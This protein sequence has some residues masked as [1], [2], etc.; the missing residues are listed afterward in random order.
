[1]RI[2]SWSPLPAMF[3]LGLSAG[4]SPAPYICNTSGDCTVAGARGWCL[5]AGDGNGY[6]VIADEICSSGLRWSDSAH[7]RIAAQCI[8]AGPGTPA[9]E[10]TCTIPVN[11]RCPPC[12]PGEQLPCTIDD[13]RAASSPCQ[14]GF[15]VCLTT[16][17][18][19][20][21]QTGTIACG[22]GACM[23]NASACRGGQPQTCVPGTPIPEICGNGIDDDCDGFIDDW[24]VHCGG[25]VYC[26]ANSA[27]TGTQICT[28][29]PGFHAVDCGGRD[30]SSGVCKGAWQCV[31]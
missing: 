21:C 30:C 4:C 26:K 11:G 23:R 8:D 3:A 25:G 27:C 19:G 28:C 1:M 31:R 14:W 2:R 16:G 6:C 29:L 10:S 7:Q 15:R 20:A 18:F 12:T 24:S 17:E 5:P 9:R 22:V 13:P